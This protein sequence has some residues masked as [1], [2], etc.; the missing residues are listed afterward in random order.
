MQR[1]KNIISKTRGEGVEYTYQKKPVN[2]FMN[3]YASK[4][5]L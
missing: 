2:S 1:E 5:A 3:V 4:G